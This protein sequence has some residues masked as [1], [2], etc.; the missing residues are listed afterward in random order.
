MTESSSFEDDFVAFQERL[1]PLMKTE[2][3]LWRLRDS[4]YNDLRYSRAGH[5]ET[6]RHRLGNFSWNAWMLRNVIRSLLRPGTRCDVHTQ[7]RFGFLFHGSQDAHFATLLP[8]V[9]ELARSEP[10]TVWRLALNHEQNSLLDKIDNVT[11]IA[12]D[13]WNEGLGWSPAR[14]SISE[15]KRASRLQSKF[16]NYS[17][18]SLEEQIQAEKKQSQ[19]TETIF[20]YFRWTRIWSRAFETLPTLALFLTSETSPPAKAVRDMM[21]EADCRVIHF[22]HGLPNTTHQVTYATDLCVYNTSQQEW[23]RQR[24]A[25]DMHVRTI[26]NPRLEQIRMSVAQTRSRRSD[27]PFRLLYF[28][29]VPGSYYDRAARRIDLAILALNDSER[30]QFLLRVRPHPAE[31]IDQLRGDLESVGITDCEFSAC[32]LVDDLSWCDVAATTFST[33]LLEAAVCDRLCY[34]ISAGEHVFRSIKDLCDDGIGKS[35]RS[36]T[37]WRDEV[38][39]I[40]N[41]NVSPPAQITEQRLQDLKIIPRTNQSWFDR[42]EFS[43]SAT[44]LATR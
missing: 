27:E 3:L 17:G 16:A 35:I 30:T 11:C 1:R 39:L 9:R 43:P 40:A 44:P 13:S 38:K 18:L 22:L 6:R 15:A 12:I 21:R 29:Q 33:A 4:L 2:P 5:E 37:E 41:L 25:K 36:A 31:S 8:I 14:T 32:S 42:L 7:P 19:I 34:W 20:E 23:F 10:V 24:V 28:S 26:G